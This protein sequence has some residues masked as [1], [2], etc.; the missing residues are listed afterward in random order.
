MNQRDFH[1]QCAVKEKITAGIA[2]IPQRENALQQTIESVIGQLDTLNV[3]LNGYEHIPKFLKHEKI[4][5]FRSQDYGDKGDAGKFFKQGRG[6]NFSLDDDLLYP[7]EY[8]DYLIEKIE[9]YGRKY[10]VGLHGVIM[11]KTP[12]KSYY[13]G[14]TQFHFL[15]ELR[16]DKPVHILG[17]GVMAFHSDTI[18]IRYEDFRI[19]NMADVWVGRLSQAQGVG[20]MCVAHSNRWV[21]PISTEDKGIYQSKKKNEKDVTAVVNEIE[22]A[23]QKPL[24]GDN[25]PVYRDEGILVRADTEEQL[26]C[27]AN[28]AMSTDAEITIQTNLKHSLTAF[29]H[30]GECPNEKII[31]L[32]PYTIF[33][34]QKS[35]KAFFD[36]PLIFD[37]DRH[38]WTRE[39]VI[40]ENYFGFIGKTGATPRRMKDLY[41]R[42]V[43]YFSEIRGVKPFFLP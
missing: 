26:M 4:R 29:D 3:Y 30:T 20:M 12:V 40:R 28:L 10:V 13:F 2:S 5:V 9:E 36:N 15:N 42:Y 32:S 21:K 22:W 35:S 31:E 34:P 33:F 16:H 37:R 19:A 17:T 11:Q 18:K 8:I 1:F 43:D 6:Y 39:D 7:L 41:N 25:I 24:H 14:R 27:A 38:G 23:L